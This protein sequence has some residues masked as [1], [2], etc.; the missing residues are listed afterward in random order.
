MILLSRVIPEEVRVVIRDWMVERSESL[1]EWSDTKTRWFRPWWEGADP[2]PEFFELKSC[3]IDALGLAEWANEDRRRYTQLSIAFDG[4]SIHEHDHIYPDQQDAEYYRTHV[5]ARINT[6]IQAPTDGGY[7]RV[8]NITFDP[9][10]EGDSWTF[11]A[12]QKHSVTR[13]MG[14]VPRIV[15]S[16]GFHMPKEEYR[17]FCEGLSC[18]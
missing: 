4:G 16:C 18:R 10:E 2:L 8:N 6:M 12:F 14:N 5:D 3:I 15:A 7:L 11:N 17:S 9:P 1:P 13:V